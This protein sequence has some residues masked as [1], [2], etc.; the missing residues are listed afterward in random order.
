MSIN[1]DS[2]GIAQELLDYSAIDDM[3][4]VNKW[5]EK[6]QLIRENSQHRCFELADT[7]DAMVVKHDEDLENCKQQYEL[8]LNEAKQQMDQQ[9]KL[10]NEIKQKVESKSAAY[11][12][13]VDFLSSIA[14]RKCHSVRINFDL[15]HNTRFFELH[16][17]LFMFVV[18]GVFP[19]IQEFIVDSAKQQQMEN[20][21][22]PEINEQE[23]H[24]DHDND[25]DNQHRAGENEQDAEQQIDQPHD[26][27]ANEHEHD[28]ADH[29]Q[30]D[31]DHGQN[32]D[33]GDVEAVNEDSDPSGAND[34]SDEENVQPQD[35]APSMVPSQPGP[36]VRHQI[37]GGTNSD[38]AK[39]C[40]LCVE[41]F[42]Q[43]G[44]YIDHLLNFHGIPVKCNVRP[45]DGEDQPMAGRY[46]LNPNKR[47][48]SNVEDANDENAGNHVG[49]HVDKRKCK[50]IL[51]PTN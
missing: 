41:T 36:S 3:G 10:I 49:K 14:Q 37:L 26:N 50:K 31:D 20:D 16:L 34:S 1:D 18:V 9:M 17:S 21:V 51:K 8:K 12:K 22:A 25:G 7:L 30:N 43:E 38:P 13:T 39:E 15:S 32:D 44:A 46:V 27:A 40:F 6:L 33:D 47:K 11:N 45:N 24:D 19:E 35:A 42:V 5:I 4:K 29:G 23:E 28:G 48:H 2:F